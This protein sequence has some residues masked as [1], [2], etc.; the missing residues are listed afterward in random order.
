MRVDDRV[1]GRSHVHAAQHA[2]QHLLVESD[3]VRT[4][5]VGEAVAGD[6]AKAGIGRHELGEWL[7]SIG[8]ARHERCDGRA[9][10]RRRRLGADDVAVDE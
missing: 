3:A 8:T 6:Q 2:L 5:L 10:N 4:V 7:G 1:D 9:G